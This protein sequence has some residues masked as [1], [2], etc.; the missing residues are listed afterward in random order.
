[1]DSVTPGTTLFLNNVLGAS[2]HSSLGDR[3]GSSGTGSIEEKLNSHTS[4]YD[5][6]HAVSRAKK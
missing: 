3:T 5:L 2:M 6:L 4:P 1:M